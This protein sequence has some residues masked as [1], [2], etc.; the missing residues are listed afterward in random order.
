MSIISK[1]PKDRLMPLENIAANIEL[2]RALL[3]E[4]INVEM[5]DI[6]MLQKHITALL[7][8]LGLADEM[9]AEIQCHYNVVESKAIMQSKGSGFSASMQN[10]WVKSQC[11]HIQVKLDYV[12]NVRDDMRRKIEAC[13][14][15]L[16]AFLE[17]Q[18]TTEQLGNQRTVAF[19]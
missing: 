3:D 1:Q 19:Q 4:V 16:K 9:L 17:T 8:H 15:L 6:I 7:A 2:L 10:K 13:R 18:E 12:R 11:A 5:A 14:S